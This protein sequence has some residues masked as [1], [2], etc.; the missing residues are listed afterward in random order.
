[1]Q[2]ANLDG[3]TA[4][5]PREAINYTQQKLK[6]E[7]PKTFKNILRSQE[8]NCF[9]EVDVPNENIYEINGTILIFK[10]YG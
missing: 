2:T 7:S 1:M 5:K 9:I 10:N 3:E 4:L 8:D 6:Y